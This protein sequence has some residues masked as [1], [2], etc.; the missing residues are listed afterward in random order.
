MRV[1]VLLSDRLGKEIVRTLSAVGL[2]VVQVGI[3]DHGRIETILYSCVWH[4]INPFSI[5]YRCY[6][7][8]FGHHR[9]IKGIRTHWPSGSFETNETFDEQ[10]EERVTW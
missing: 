2:W 7:V 6:K 4:R 9:R 8:V 5:F 10:Y 1:S 3:I